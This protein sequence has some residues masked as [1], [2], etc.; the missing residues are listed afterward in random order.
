MH[1]F[2]DIADSTSLVSLSDMPGAIEIDG[3]AGTVRVPAQLPFASFVEQIDARGWALGNMGSLPHLSVGGATATATHGSGLRNRNLSASVVGIDLVAADGGLLRLNRADPRFPAAGVH[4]GML[5]I[6]THVT[7][8]IQPRYHVRQDVY[9]NVPWTELLADPHGVLDS[10]YSVSV[11][12]H[13]G[14]KTARV[15]R[16]HRLLAEQEGDTNG[17]WCGGSRAVEQS[18]SSG[19]TSATSPSSANPAHGMRDCRT[20]GSIGS[21]LQRARRSRRST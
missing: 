1:S 3:C 16:K 6:V 13:W 5:G 8:A 21:P 9:L 12:A 15:W 20:S 7:L 2:N 10:G 17:T 14:S 4:L 18:R 11:F 19:R